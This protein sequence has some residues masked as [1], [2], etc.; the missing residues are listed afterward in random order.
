MAILTPVQVEQQ[1]Q[2]LIN[3]LAQTDSH[4]GGY[5]LPTIN[6][7][8]QYGGTK[9]DY[10]GIIG[11]LNDDMGQL[12]Q[13]YRTYPSE[14]I[15]ERY[16]MLMGLLGGTRDKIVDL[17]NRGLLAKQWDTIVTYLN[18]RFDDVM[19]S[20][21]VKDTLK[22]WKESVENVA[23]AEANLG[24]MK[25]ADRAESEKAIAL[26][27]VMMAGIRTATLGYIDTLAN[28]QM[29]FIQIA[30]IPA[31]VL[32][33]GVIVAVATLYV[34]ARVAVKALDVVSKLP[35]WAIGGIAAT[36]ISIFALPKI[37]GKKKPD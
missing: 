21:M 22:K 11:S 27:K 10:D 15:K 36:L 16:T 9:A 5:Y 31:G 34:I 20:G 17:S 1:L 13:L 4:K 26:A 2:P 25:P 14:V 6:R 24:K 18:N 29:G 35:W 37:L 19:N 23:K 3:R 7:L 12:D 32:I 28:K 30:A 8:S 33:A